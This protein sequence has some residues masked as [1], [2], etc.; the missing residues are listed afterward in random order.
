MT[1]EK[2]AAEVAV[3]PKTHSLTYNGKP[4][5]LAMSGIAIGGTMLYSLDGENWSRSVP[6]GIKA[7]SYKLYYMVQGDENHSDLPKA[8][9]KDPE[10]P[11]IA[12]RNLVITAEH[13]E[14]TYGE[15]D[16]ELTFL[17][18]GLVKGDSLVGQLTRETGEEVGNY[19]I[20]SQAIK[21]ADFCKDNYN[22]VP[23]GDV[24]TINPADESGGS[25]GDG[26][27]LI[28]PVQQV[29]DK[30]NALTEPY[31]K[32]A[33]AE[34]R[35]AY[36]KLTDEQK[37]DKRFTEEIMKKLTDAEEAVDRAEA[38]K[39]SELIAAMPDDPAQVTGDQIS[40][41]VSAYK[42]LS[43]SAKKLVP[44]AQ[45]EKLQTAMGYQASTQTIVLKKA[46]AKKGRKVIAK[47]TEN[48]AVDGY[49]LYY[50]AK[51]VKAKRVI[52]AG[53]DKL[54]KKVRKMRPGKKYTFKVRTYT[55]VENL[56]TGETTNVYGKWSNKKKAKAKR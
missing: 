21:P 33:V 47:W 13:K 9:I 38:A 5:R 3:E 35:E 41:A 44:A 53:A 19:L 11:S 10:S 7:G 27:G 29:I 34:T 2:A 52:V 31:D 15:P 32:A 39:F 22:V 25:S 1:I 12:K 40:K 55:K 23:Q 20:S 46:K 45:L 50:K 26:G 16:P 49:Q 28:D 24:L 42:A 43:D 17:V 36:N 4:Q 48:S 56:A 37:A 14:K 8:E 30:I 54:K 6:T 51:G 18:D